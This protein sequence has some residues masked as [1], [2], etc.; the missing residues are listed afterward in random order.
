[1]VS[2]YLDPDDEKHLFCTISE[3]FRPITKMVIHNK[4]AMEAYSMS[5]KR[6]FSPIGYTQGSNLVCTNTSL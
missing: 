2:N 5:M 1:M 6:D 4:F 3:Q